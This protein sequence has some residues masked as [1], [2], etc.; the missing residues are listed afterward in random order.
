MFYSIFQDN[1]KYSSCPQRFPQLIILRLKIKIFQTPVWIQGIDW[2][3]LTPCAAKREANSLLIQ[4]RMR[5]G[6]TASRQALP[7]RP[8]LQLLKKMEEEE[9][10][11]EREDKEAED[12]CGPLLG[13]LV[14]D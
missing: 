7:R 11:E 10:V 14:I 12:G 4:A 3:S 1:I 6:G 8:T 9:H 5:R 13:A 2:R